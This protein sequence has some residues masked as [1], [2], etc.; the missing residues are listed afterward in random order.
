[1]S[2]QTEVNERVVLRH[3]QEALTQRKAEVWDTILHPDYVFHHPMVK[4]GRASYV[5]VATKFWDAC[6]APEYTILHMIAE[7]NFVMS[8]YIE[9]ATILTPLFGADAVGKRY[10]KHGFALYRLENGQ[11]REA[12]NQEDDLGFMK[13]LG[14]TS[15]AL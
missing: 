6:S 10:E 2:D 3:L 7:G 13:Q 4:P 11:M 9:R 12:W 8:H 15:F 5:S 14:I 1:M